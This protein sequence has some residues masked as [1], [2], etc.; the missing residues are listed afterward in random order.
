MG[1][2]NS[3]SNTI[4]GAGIGAISQ[5]NSLIGYFAGCSI[6]GDRN[7]IIG[8]RAGCNLT[9]VGQIV[10][11]GNLAGASVG[12][13]GVVMIGSYAGFLPSRGSTGIGA[14]SLCGGYSTSYS[15][16][17]IGVLSNPR[18]TSHSVSVGAPSAF[19]AYG[20][21]G[22]VNL[23]WRAGDF[24]YN[25]NNTF[26]G[27][28]AGYTGGNSNNTTQIGFNTYGGDCQNNCFVIGNYSSSNAYAYASWTSVSDLRDKKNIENLPNNLGLNFIRKLRPV[29]FKY[30]YREKYMFKCGFEF[31]QKDGT[32]KEQKENYGFLAQQIENV[33]KELNVNFDGVVYDKFNDKYQVKI[34]ELI[35]PIVKS[36]QELN[37]ELD[38]IEK[39]IG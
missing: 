38:I 9:A 4:F 29:A 33:A 37:N 17:A 35:S 36:I 34:L 39:Q 23:G 14:C 3:G 18:R 19:G 30:D 16:V 7:T 24:V 11:V 28:R 6:S 25:R 8:S 22:N 26:V 13:G 32:L 2:N 20:A 31:G 15:S 27:A 21:D 1:C 12:N 10:A 5:Q